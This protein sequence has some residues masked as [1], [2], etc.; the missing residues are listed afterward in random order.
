[1]ERPDHKD[2][3]EPG[4]P[5]VPEVNLE[6]TELQ[7]SPASEARLGS[8]DQVASL[9]LPGLAENLDP[10]EPPDLAAKLELPYVIAFPQHPRS[11]VVEWTFK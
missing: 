7:D 5:R 8:P 2:L 11:E 10:V 1:M 4:V 6:R 9:A 3:K